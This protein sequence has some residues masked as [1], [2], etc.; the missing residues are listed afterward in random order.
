MSNYKVS[1]VVAGFKIEIGNLQ[2]LFRYN[3]KLQDFKEEEPNIEIENSQKS[4]IPQEIINKIKEDLPIRSYYS[5]KLN[6]KITHIYPENKLIFEIMN[7]KKNE[8]S[9]RQQNIINSFTELIKDYKQDIYAIGYNIT[10]LI[11]LNYKL[12]LLNKGIETLKDW[13]TNTS[14]Q[15]ILPFQ[16]NN[17]VLTT[18]MIQKISENFQNESKIRDYNIS[19]NF[20]KFFNSEEIEDVKVFLSHCFNNFISEFEYNKQQILKIGQDNVE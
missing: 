15:V 9:K 13:D 10:E 20:N 5:K 17:N 16:N 11:S 8:I 19:A 14:F 7:F 12:Q 4:Q 18:Y 3:S 6:C 2:C 1:I